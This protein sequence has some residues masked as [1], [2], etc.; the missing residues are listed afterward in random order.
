MEAQA[1]GGLGGII[2]SCQPPRWHEMPCIMLARC[3]HIASLMVD[4]K[5]ASTPANDP[6]QGPL[7][8]LLPYL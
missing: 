1:T 7:R 3:W 4:F 5:P 8:G 6:L 2:G